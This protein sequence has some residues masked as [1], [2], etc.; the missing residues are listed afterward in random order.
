MTFIKP[1]LS[2]HAGSV[3]TTFNLIQAATTAFNATRSRNQ[4][5]PVETLFIQ[6]GILYL[7]RK[8]KPLPAH[9]QSAAAQRP[10]DQQHNP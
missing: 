5:K 3:P 6:C 7:P 1:H 2:S 10:P 9:C 4:Q 8:T